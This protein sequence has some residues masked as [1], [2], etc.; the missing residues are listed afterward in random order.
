M[1]D[2]DR[3]EIAREYVFPMKHRLSPNGAASRFARKIQ[4]IILEEQEVNF[5]TRLHAGRLNIIPWY[6][7][8]GY[9]LPISNSYY[10]PVIESKEFYK[11]FP[12]LKK[13]L[14]QQ[15]VTHNAAGKFLYVMKTLMAKLKVCGL[16]PNLALLTKL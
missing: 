12:A 6:V 15:V 13:R 1:A 14:D 8:S 9:L 2:S 16:C 4:E 7:T 5:I 3:T 11:L 10:R